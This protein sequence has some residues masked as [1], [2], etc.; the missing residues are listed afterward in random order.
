VFILIATVSLSA[1]GQ[2]VEVKAKPLTDD[3]IKLLRQDLQTAKDTIISHTMQLSESESTAF[4]P[5]YREY[6]RAQHSLAEKRLAI[7]TEYAQ[8]LDKMD[9]EKATSLTERFFK[10]DGD[11][12]AL[13]REYFPKFVAAISAKRAAKF[14]Q[15]DNRL[16]MMEDV[17]LASEIPLI[18]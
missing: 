3:D 13:Q 11:A 7:I 2:T 17:Q 16:T 5:V 9:N 14:I 10:I 4:W 12:Q 18:P 8:H 6:S 1:F 15:I